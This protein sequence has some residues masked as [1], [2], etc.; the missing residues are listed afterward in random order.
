M[1]V[2]RIKWS[3]P[4]PYCVPHQSHYCPCL[5][6]DS[7]NPLDAKDAEHIRGWEAIA[8]IVVFLND[9]PPPEYEPE[10]VSTSVNRVVRIPQGQWEVIS[11]D[12]ALKDKRSSQAS[13]TRRWGKDFNLLGEMGE[14]LYEYLSGIP[15]RRGFGDGGQDFPGIDIKTTSYLHRPHLF[16]PESEEM[17]ALFYALICADVDSRSCWYV[18]HATRDEMARAEIKMVQGLRARAIRSANLNPELPP[19]VHP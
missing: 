4:H 19:E 3:G 18:G 14:W 2:D 16:Y 8:P 13:W 17:R 10:P 12:A 1:D 6:P 5:K 11:E 7:Y 9:E 15:R